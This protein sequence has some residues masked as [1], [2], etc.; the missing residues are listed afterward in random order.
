M[1]LQ[2]SNAYC[3][4]VTLSRWMITTVTNGIHLFASLHQR[5]MLVVA[6]DL[7]T[8]SLQMNLLYDMQDASSNCQRRRKR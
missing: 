2:I 1:Y 6:M 4:Y 5:M 3:M 7:S 8:C